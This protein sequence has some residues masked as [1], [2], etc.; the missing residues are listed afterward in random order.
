MHNFGLKCGLL[1][2]AACL[3]GVS[4]QDKTNDCSVLEWSCFL[5]YVK[6][7]ELVTEV[8]TSMFFLINVLIFPNLSPDNFDNLNA[9]F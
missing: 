9:Y 7:H 5:V 8:R 3:C 6:S 1:R 4:F 2:A